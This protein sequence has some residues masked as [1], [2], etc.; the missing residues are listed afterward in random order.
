MRKLFPL[1]DVPDEDEEATAA[2]QRTSYFPGDL[3]STD[4]LLSARV[5]VLLLFI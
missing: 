2:Q 1:K 4:I 5:P 3:P